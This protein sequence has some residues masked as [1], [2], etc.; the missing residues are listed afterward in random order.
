MK[1]IDNVSMNCFIHPSQMKGGASGVVTG[2]PIRAGIPVCEIKGDVFENEK[3]NSDK[4]RNDLI[5]M[6]SII[7]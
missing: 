7:H 3:D 6:E 5:Q 1:I 2:S 4:Q